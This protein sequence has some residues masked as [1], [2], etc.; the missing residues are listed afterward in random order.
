MLT[1]LL[2]PDF[3]AMAARAASLP[4]GAFDADPR[5]SAPDVVEAVAAARSLSSDAATLYLQLPRAEAE[6]VALSAATEA[7][8]RWCR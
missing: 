7:R 8:V 4:P 2:S 1:L 5:V 6:S 3:E